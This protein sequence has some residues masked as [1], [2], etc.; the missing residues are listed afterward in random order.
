MF[1]TPRRNVVTPQTGRLAVELGKF[2][3]RLQTWLAA[4]GKNEQ[5][6]RSDPI[7]AMREAGKVLDQRRVARG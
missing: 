5:L 3:G 6:F 1:A 7:T 4:S 2:E